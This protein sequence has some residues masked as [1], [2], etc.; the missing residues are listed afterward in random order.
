M[1]FPWYKHPKFEI[2][3]N[4]HF[5]EFFIEIKTKG[6]FP[7]KW[8][9]WKKVPGPTFRSFDACLDI[10]EKL[11]HSQLHANKKVK[12]TSKAQWTI[13]KLSK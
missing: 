13:I 5:D 2:R 11:K 6:F 8:K 9:S 10:L 12:K 3:M 1:K 4:S 7:L